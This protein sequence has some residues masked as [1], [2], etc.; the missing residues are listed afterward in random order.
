MVDREKDWLEKR[1]AVR[2]GTDLTRGGST[3]KHIVDLWFS[4]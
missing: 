2:K 4:R 3:V 1:S